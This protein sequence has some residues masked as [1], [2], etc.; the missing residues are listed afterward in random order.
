MSST[1]CTRV[2][3]DEFHSSR[4]VRRHNRRD[5][6]V[7]FLVGRLLD[8]DKDIAGA[9]ICQVH[10]GHGCTNGGEGGTVPS[11]SLSHVIISCDG[12]HATSLLCSCSM[13]SI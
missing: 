9:A 8:N 12:I 2:V 3:G 7:M 1:L 5:I 4:G 11:L 10:T 6:R 13:R